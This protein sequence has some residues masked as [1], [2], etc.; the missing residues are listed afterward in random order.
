MLTSSLKPL[1]NR[2]LSG[3][4]PSGSVIKPLIALAALEEGIINPEREIL[5]TGSI[6]VPNPFDPT[7]PNIFYDWKE[8]G[9]VDM[10]KA[11]AVS[12]NVYFYTIGG[13]YEETKGLGVKK[14][15]AWLNKFGF[16]EKT[17]I[18]I[19]GEKEGFVPSPEW[20]AET[21]SED[22]IWRVG[23][24]Y[25]L[26]I[27]QGNFQVT[28]LQMA[29]F[30][31]TLANEGRVLEPT[32]IK[33]IKDKERVIYEV[34]TKA[35]K[36]LKFKQENLK[37]I[38]E[39]MRLATEFGTAQALSGLRVKV[40][41]KT[42]TAEIGSGKSVNSWFIGFVPYEKPKIAMAVVLERGTAS[43]LVGAPSAARQ[44]IEWITVYRPKLLS[45]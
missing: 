38:K 11:I 42:G 6:S 26:S 14:I 44:I 16:G 39:G 30:A 32:I 9:W 35:R 36:T 24:T 15:Q 20:K 22:P 41:A 2:A 40:A 5:S 23:D 25:N 1:F 27:G 43:N 12:S 31:A 3:L 29:L 28:P 13:G 45:L 7:K 8:H 17:G 37:V 34:N 10:R 33:T 21:Q 19:K 4:Y 18:D